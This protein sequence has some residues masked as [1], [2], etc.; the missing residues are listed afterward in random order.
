MTRHAYVY[1][2]LLWLAFV[3]LCVF[4]VR[5]L[6]PQEFRQPKPPK[7][8]VFACGGKPILCPAGTQVDL[9]SWTGLW[10][11]CHQAK[12]SSEGVYECY[13]VPHQP[14]AQCQ[15]ANGIWHKYKGMNWHN[16][17]V[18]PNIWRNDFK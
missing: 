6:Y 13:P 15:D 16:D 7:S 10:D 9:N 17:C 5:T 1:A 2:I 18:T 8:W 12:L 11:E 14:P 3:F 4:L